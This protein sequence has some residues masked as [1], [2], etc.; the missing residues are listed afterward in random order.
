MLDRYWTYWTTFA[1]DV[2]W[3]LYVGREFCVRDPS[4]MDMPVAP[5]VDTELDELPFHHP[6]SGIPPQPNQL[7]KIFASTCELLVI[8]RRIMNVVNGIGKT[9]RTRQSILDE[10]NTITEIEYVPPPVIF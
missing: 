2:N 7:S 6:P 3:S 10:S 8:G 1:Q 5:Y 9:P 4:E